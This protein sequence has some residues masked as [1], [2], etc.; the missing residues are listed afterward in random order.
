MASPSTFAAFFPNDRA[1]RSLNWHEVVGDALL[2]VSLPFL[3]FPSALLPLGFFAV[4]G[5][6]AWRWL[7]RA[8]PISKTRVNALLL[9]LLVM[10]AIGLRI[11]PEPAYSTVTVAHILVGVTLFFAIQDW[12]TWPNAVWRILELTVLLGLGFT[13]ASP[14]VTSGAWNKLFNIGFLDMRFHAL[15]DQPSNPNIVAGMLGPMLPL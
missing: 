5:W 7:W 15:L 9:L 8:S 2:F 12:G 10:V 11:A 4:L 1:T 14:F 3:F 13:L 6:Y